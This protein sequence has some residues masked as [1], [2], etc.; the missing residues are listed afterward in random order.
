MMMTMQV[1]M[2]TCLLE[3]ILDSAGVELSWLH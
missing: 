1:M 2:V 3:L